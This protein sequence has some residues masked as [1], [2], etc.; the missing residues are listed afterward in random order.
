MNLH[1]ALLMEFLGHAV[2]DGRR[3]L[4]PMPCHVDTDVLAMSACGYAAKLE[5]APELPK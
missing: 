2:A 4:Y 3:K 1:S 5:L